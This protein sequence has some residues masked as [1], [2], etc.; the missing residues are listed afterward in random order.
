MGHVRFIMMPHTG[1]PQM[2]GADERDRF[3]TLLTTPYVQWTSRNVAEPPYL[4]GTKGMYNIAGMYELVNSSLQIFLKIDWS[5]DT[6]H[7]IAFTLENI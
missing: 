7:I 5:L 1:A 4:S 3:C 2:A 6:F